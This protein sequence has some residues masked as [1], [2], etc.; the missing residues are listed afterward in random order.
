MKIIKDIEGTALAQF[1]N[2]G[3]NLIYLHLPC[4][5]GINWGIKTS[6]SSEEIDYLLFH[7]LVFSQN[8]VKFID[9]PRWASFS[10]VLGIFE[11]CSILVE[12]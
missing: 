10:S 12:K 9:H 3:E 4:N 5:L 7:T 11:D 6:K 2:K 1:E 8:W